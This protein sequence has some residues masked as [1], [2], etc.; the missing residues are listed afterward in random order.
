FA[1]IESFYPAGKRIVET[2]DFARDIPVLAN[3]RLHLRRFRTLF[4]GGLFVIS[5]HLKRG[6]DLHKVFRAHA[7]FLYPSRAF[8]WLDSSTLQSCVVHLSTGFMADL[9]ASENSPVS[10]DQIVKFIASVLDRQKA[11]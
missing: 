11:N 2:F 1:S 7:G 5:F 4:K 3:W 10:N 6:L 8:A 9:N